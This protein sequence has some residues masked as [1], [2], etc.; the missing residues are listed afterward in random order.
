MKKLIDIDVETAETNIVIA[1]EDIVNCFKKGVL[2]AKTSLF[3]E[4]SFI[5]G[6]VSIYAETYG[7][8]LRVQYWLDDEILPD[9]PMEKVKVL[10][11]KELMSLSEG[12]VQ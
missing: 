6:W 10:S 4:L 9:I 1:T 7:N 5:E 3:E 8:G 12:Q 2:L 11:K